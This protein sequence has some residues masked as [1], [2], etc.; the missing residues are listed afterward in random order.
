MKKFSEMVKASKKEKIDFLNAIK[1]GE[2]DPGNIN[3]NTVIVSDGSDAFYGLMVAASNAKPGK[4]RVVFIGEAK[5]ELE[6]CMENI[7]K[8]REKVKNEISKCQNNV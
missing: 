1:Q 5:R 3:P 4:V 2:I 8:N 6:L 7:L